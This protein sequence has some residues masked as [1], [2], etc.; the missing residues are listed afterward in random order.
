MEEFAETT[1]M[2]VTVGGGGGGGGAVTVRVAIVL[3]PFAQ[4]LICVDPAAK[5]V[6]IP[7]V[8]PSEFTAVTDATIVLELYQAKVIPVITLLY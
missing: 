5:P 7:S 1:L 8:S 3:T 2:V 4:A 6:A